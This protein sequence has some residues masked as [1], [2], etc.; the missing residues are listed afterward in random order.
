M[1]YWRTKAV[2]SLKRIKIEE[3][4]LWTTYRNSLTLFRTVPSP[5]PY[6]LPFPPNWGS[7]PPL[8]IAIQNFGQTSADR[9]II[10]TEGLFRTVQS[11][12][13]YGLPYLEIGGLQLSYRS[14]CDSN[15]KPAYLS[16]DIADP[17]F[18]LSA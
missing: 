5:T 16:T 12:T 9:G 7:Q 4:L 6:G 14:A 3:K 11:P 8:K 1:A 10:C 17:T 18:Y 2:I 15:I 13:L